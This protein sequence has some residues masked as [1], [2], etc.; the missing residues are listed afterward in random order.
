MVEVRASAT[1]ALTGVVKAGK[2]QVIKFETLERRLR[3]EAI[4]CMCTPDVLWRTRT[5]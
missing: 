1:V 2:D 5:S 3:L 4:W